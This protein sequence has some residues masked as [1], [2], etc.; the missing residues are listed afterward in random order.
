MNRDDVLK[1]VQPLL[2]CPTAPMFESAVRGEI[3]RQLSD[4]QGLKLQ[5]DSYGNLI[6]WYGGKRPKYAFVAHMDHPGWQLR[7]TRRFLGGV[8]EN[9]QDK[10]Q[11]QEFGEFGMWDLPA[12]RLDGDRLY[13]RACDDLIGCATINATLRTLSERAS[14]GS[15]AGV[16]TRAEEVGFIGAIHLA[17]SKL[18]PS[19][20][21]IIS[22]ETSKEILPAKMGEG[23]IV[24]V[25]DRIS[26]FDPQ[27]T[28]LFVEIARNEKIGSQRCLMPGGACEASA[29]QLYGYRSAALCIALGNYH[30]CTPDGRIDSEFI[31]LGDL[32]GLIALCVAI[33]MAEET[34]ES[35]REELR[36]RLETRLEEFP[37]G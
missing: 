20:A 37:L 19:D 35:A 6:A 7:P 30:N 18:L 24:R 34:A 33:G 14:S 22:L 29:F 10:G 5:V 15:V 9:L 23:P 17:K 3:N 25:G 27:T 16:F 2:E 13:S 21:T 32:E 8:P 26:I 28:D 12:F 1:I 31:D 36:K 4:I 11:V